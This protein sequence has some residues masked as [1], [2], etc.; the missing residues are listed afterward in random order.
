MMMNPKN[1]Q[2]SPDISEMSWIGGCFS[3]CRCGGSDSFMTSMY[4]LRAPLTV[5]HN[6]ER[7]AG[8][9]DRFLYFIHDTALPDLY[10]PANL[11]GFGR[12]QNSYTETSRSEMVGVDLHTYSDC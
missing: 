8:D 3:D 2:N 4:L 5:I 12:G 7:T 6:R 11:N 10:G 1:T 9:A